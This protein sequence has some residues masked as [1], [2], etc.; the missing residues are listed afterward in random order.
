MS[1]PKISRRCP[2]CGASLRER[3]FFCP[4]CG[5]AL[6]ASAVD[7]AAAPATQPLDEPPGVR[8]D[9]NETLIERPPVTSS[10]KTRKLDLSQRNQGRRDRR[11]NRPQ[12]EEHSASATSQADGKGRT[13]TA[14]ARDASESSVLQRVEKIRKVSS[15]MIDEAAYDPSFRFVLVAL[16][17]FVLFLVIVI[18]NKIIG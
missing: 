16:V 9:L 6:E 3:A 10:V 2:A 4:Q 18:L 8:S 12:P 1:E 7:P 14:V 13:N 11:K 5:L 15:V 17:L